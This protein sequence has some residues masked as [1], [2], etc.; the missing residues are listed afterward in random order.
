M[1]DPLNFEDGIISCYHCGVPVD[2]VDAETVVRLEYRRNIDY[3]NQSEYT[4]QRLVVCPGCQRRLLRWRWLSDL[5]DRWVMGLI[6]AFAGG[7]GV[8]L[9]LIFI[10]ALIRVR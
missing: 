9:L 7:A 6:L 10:T 4:R 2:A 8:L 1:S 3:A 5:K